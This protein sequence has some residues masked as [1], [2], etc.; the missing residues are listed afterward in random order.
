MKVHPI[1]RGELW[2]A[3]IVLFIAILLQI[4]VWAI[5]PDLTYGPHGVIVVTELALSVIIGIGA[6][7]RHIAPHSLYRTLSFLL[8]G[9]ISFANIVSFI[10][11][12]RLLI[13]GNQVLSGRE[14][15]VAALAILLT[16]VIV[17]ALWYWEIDSPG[18]T[19]S[20]WSK[21]D[22]DFQFIQQDMGRDFVG[23]QPTFVD[24]LYLSL[25]NAINF[26]PADARPITHGAKLLMGTQALVSVFT[27]A[28]IL[29]RSISILN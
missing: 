1:G 23:W 29:S 11:V 9:L 8:L 24:Y 4:A 14:L 17:F 10:L 28:L 16:N 12:A 18:L 21:H 3:Q 7:R 27:L 26:A 13:I 20:K 5:N 15:L 22:K 6:S 2:V 19:G 25:T